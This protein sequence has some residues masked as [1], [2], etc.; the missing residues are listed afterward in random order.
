[1]L[2]DRVKA[3][4]QQVSQEAHDLLLK[5]K[6]IQDQAGEV[7]KVTFLRNLNMLVAELRLRARAGLTP[8][9]CHDSIPWADV[10]YVEHMR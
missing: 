9:T 6:L 1:M 4:A 2:L 3:L 8:L 5:H 7:L 10:K